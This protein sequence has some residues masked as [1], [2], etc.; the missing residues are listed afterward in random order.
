M[1]TGHFVGLRFHS[2]VSLCTA[3]AGEEEEEEEEEAISRYV[4][5]LDRRQV[6]LP[7]PPPPPRHFSSVRL[8]PRRPWPRFI[9]HPEFG[10]VHRPSHSSHCLCRNLGKT[11]VQDA[12]DPLFFWGGAFNL[13]ERQPNHST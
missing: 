11:L 3:P 1:F 10:D 4:A 13:R 12:V 9:S 2:A 5:V 7:P 6:S 8:S